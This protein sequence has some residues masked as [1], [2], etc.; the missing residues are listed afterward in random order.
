MDMLK[1]ATCNELRQMLNAYN[2]AVENP[3]TQFSRREIE[4]MRR[5]IHGLCNSLD[6]LE[7]HG[8]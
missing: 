8:F 3:K 7:A 6:L 5:K 2:G 1:D 4:K